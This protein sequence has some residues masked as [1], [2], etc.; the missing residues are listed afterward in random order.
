MASLYQLGW[1][2]GSVLSVA[3]DTTVAAAS[4]GGAELQTISHNRWVVVS[5]DCDLDSAHSEGTDPRIELRPVY[6]RHGGPAFDRGSPDAWGVRSRK[7]RLNT[8]R[9]F[10]HADS[11]RL[12]ASPALLSQFVDARQTLLTDGRTA[13][14]SAWLGRRYDRPAVPDGLVEL[15][16]AVGRSASRTGHRV[17]DHL[18]DLL[19][20]FDESTTPP[21]VALFAITCDLDHSEPCCTGQC[22]DDH[23]ADA[24]A[25]MGEI[26]QA[27]DVEVGVVARIEAA[28]RAGTSMLIVETSFSADVTDITYGGRPIAGVG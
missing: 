19:M 11:P 4:Q 17:R 16:R 26:A 7:F 24:R 5:Q 18:H 22:S 13:A 21:E 23:V 10:V 20:A 28:P 27:L 1:R 6:D 9:D 8:E 2:Q 12:M 15:A 25:W 14:F 3:L